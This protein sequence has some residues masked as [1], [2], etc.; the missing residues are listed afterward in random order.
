MLNQRVRLLMATGRRDEARR[1]AQRALALLR[2]GTEQP[3]AGGEAFNEY[4]WA[5]VSTE[6]EDV[7]NPSL[8]LKYATRAVERAGSANPV[9]LHTLGWAHYRLG[10]HQEA[11]RTLEQA[12]K[13]MPPATTGPAVGLRRQVETDLAVFNSKK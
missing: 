8:A 5:L 6:V 4:A 7:R 12:L 9:Y 10:N 1:D 3:G 2:A 13:T 11:I